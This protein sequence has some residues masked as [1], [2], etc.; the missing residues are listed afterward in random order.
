VPVTWSCHRMQNDNATPPVVMN[1]TFAI[2]KRKKGSH[3]EPKQGQ[4]NQHPTPNVHRTQLASR[5]DPMQRIKQSS[6][7]ATPVTAVPVETSTG[8]TRPSKKKRSVE[9]NSDVHP[10]KKQMPCSAQQVDVADSRAGADDSGGAAK[11]KRFTLFVGNMP[12]NVIE[13]DVRQHF[14]DCGVVGCR[15]LRNKDTGV[16]KGIAFLDLSDSKGFVAAIKLHHSVLGGRTINVEPTAGGGGNSSQRMDKIELKKKR[17]EKVIKEG[18]MEKKVGSSTSRGVFHK[19]T[20][21]D[22]ERSK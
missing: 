15:L 1:F 19:P 22:R 3:S 21:H 4:G 16:G 14:A 7:G 11:A 18:V 10:P 9:S 6:E 12:F 20:D 8:G 17:L 2:K 5:S 13:A